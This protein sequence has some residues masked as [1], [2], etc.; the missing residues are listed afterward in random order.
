MGLLFSAMN[1]QAYTP[2]TA[3]QF[4]ITCQ[5]PNNMSV[6]RAYISGIVD[7]IFVYYAINDRNYFR[8]FTKNMQQWNA[9]KLRVA[10]LKWAKNNEQEVKNKSAADM[11]NQFLYSIYLKPSASPC[12]G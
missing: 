11:I 3:Q 7:D 1:A 8:T 10:L 2:A 12:R 5:Q 9:E 4:L 6:C